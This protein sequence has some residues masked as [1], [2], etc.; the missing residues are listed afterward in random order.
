MKFLLIFLFVLFVQ[1]CI[2]GSSLPNS[3]FP[4]SF[5]LKPVKVSVTDLPRDAQDKGVFILA[6][7]SLSSKKCNPL[8]KVWSMMTN[9]TRQSKHYQMYFN[10]RS[11]SFNEDG[12]Q[13]EELSLSAF[14]EKF[15]MHVVVR[16]YDPALPRYSNSALDYYILN[17]MHGRQLAATSPS[18]RAFVADFCDFFFDMN[19]FS[20]DKL[21]RRVAQVVSAVATAAAIL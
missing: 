1:L 15:K 20:N 4:S 16:S 14:L 5:K 7:L 18:S 21:M 10:G 12:Y 19:V 11:I 3:D 17:Y 2:G 13:N 6:E 9:R 8:R